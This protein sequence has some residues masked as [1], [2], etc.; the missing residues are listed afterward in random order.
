MLIIAR[1]WL[2]ALDNTQH[3]EGSLQ[4]KGYCQRLL[5]FIPAWLCLTYYKAC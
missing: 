5:A 4:Y 3:I 2:F 1:G